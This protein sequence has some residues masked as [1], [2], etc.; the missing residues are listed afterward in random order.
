[1]K[2]KIF[3]YLF[4]FSILFILYQYMYAK[5]IHENHEKNLVTLKAKV[6][7]KD[8]I[9][10]SNTLVVDSLI[11]VNDHHFALHNDEYAL[12]YMEDMGY[13]AIE[14]GRIIEDQLIDQNKIDADNPIVPYSGMEGKM[15]INKVAVINHKWVIADFTDG[16]YWGQLFLLYTIAK[17]RTI[18]LEVKESFLYPKP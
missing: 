13:D 8:S 16:T 6:K 11:R 5:K 7:T 1:M 17:D 2:S 15:S 3:M 12:S 4:I 9:L 14:I 10:A 18:A